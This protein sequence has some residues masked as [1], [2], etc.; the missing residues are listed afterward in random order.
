MVFAGSKREQDPA[1][2]AMRRRAVVLGGG[3][4]KG[5]YQVG[6]WRAFR[7]LGMGFHVVTGTSVG[8]LNGALMAQGSYREAVEMW[9]EVS[10][11]RILAD[12]PPVKEDRPDSVR[13]AYRAYIREIF[14]SGGVDASPLEERVRQLLDESRLRGSGVIYGI[15]TVAMDTLKPV[16]LFA[17]EIPQGML[18]D[19]MMASAACFPAFRPRKIGD[20]KYIDGGYHDVLP[21]ELALRASPPVDEI[22]AVDI[23]GIGIRRNTRTCV[24]VHTIRCLWDLGSMLIFEKNQSRRNMALGYLDGLKALGGCDGRAYAFRK[25]QKCILEERYLET[26]KEIYS[27]IFDAMPDTVRGQAERLVGMRLTDAAVRRKAGTPDGGELLLACAE[28]AGE[29]LDVVPTE[30]YTVE[31]FNAQLLQSL[32]MARGESAGEAMAQAVKHLPVT[33]LGEALRELTQGAVLQ[34]CMETV[35]QS[36]MGGEPLLGPELLAVAAPRQMLAAL[37]L[38][39]LKREQ[40]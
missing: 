30:M 12:V 29:L 38:W 25:G 34:L 17:H 8:A 22:Y 23:D 21:V 3:G 11:D 26:M 36:L 6:V 18:A 13:E 5:A 14:R 32:E 33:K 10:N 28:L 20:K 24:P 2:Q 40:L 35:K 27:G 15:V 9:E 4:A 37:Y 39:A 19:Y 1:G 7:E 31:T 16:E